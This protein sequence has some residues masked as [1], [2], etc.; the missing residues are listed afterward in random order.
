M[1][2]SCISNR[3]I[4]VSEAFGISGAI[5]CRRDAVLDTS[6]LHRKIQEQDSHRMYVRITSLL[7]FT[8]N[9][10]EARL[11]L[12]IV[13]LCVSLIVVWLAH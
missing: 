12:R 4:E 3:I 5:I 2:F 8:S 11:N 10:D 6:N 9:T 1:Y 13:L 7:Y